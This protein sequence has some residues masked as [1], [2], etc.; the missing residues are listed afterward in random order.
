MR[1]QSTHLWG[2]QRVKVRLRHLPEQHR[3]P[4]LLK[5]RR[6]LRRRLVGAKLRVAEVS[7]LVVPQRWPLQQ[8]RQQ[9][10]AEPGELLARPRQLLQAPT[11]L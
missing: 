5:L 4:R 10:Q 2:K 7:Q 11:C 3:R 8:Q 1:C 6:P 9:P